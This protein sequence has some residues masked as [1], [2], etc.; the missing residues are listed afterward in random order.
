MSTETQ[1]TKEVCLLFNYS[2][3]C[4]SANG[5]PLYNE[6]YP[7]SINDISQLTCMIDKAHGYGYR[8][9]GFILDRGYFSKANLN[10]WKKTVTVF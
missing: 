4:D 6:L 1:K 2:V 9:I 5:E 8:N 10:I 3:A 7:G